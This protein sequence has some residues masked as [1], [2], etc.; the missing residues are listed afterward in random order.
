M[1]FTEGSPLY[2]NTNAISPESLK[3]PG[4][5]NSESGWF[6]S[7][8]L[9]GGRILFENDCCACKGIYFEFINQKNDSQKMNIKHSWIEQ[10]LRSN[11]P[12]I[13]QIPPY[14]MPELED[15]QEETLFSCQIDHK[16]SKTKISN[17]I[18]TNTR[19]LK[20]YDFYKEF[21]VDFEPKVVYVYNT[22]ILQS[23]IGTKTFPLLNES[24]FSSDIDETSKQ[25][26]GFTIKWL[27]DLLSFGLITKM[28]EALKF[29]SFFSPLL[30]NKQ[31]E[32][33]KIIN[34]SI[35]DYFLNV[36]LK[37]PFLFRRLIEQWDEAAFYNFY[38]LRAHVPNIKYFYSQHLTFK[39]V[40]E[41]KN[42][43]ICEKIKQ[44]EDYFDN[45]TLQEAINNFSTLS[46]QV[47]SLYSQNLTKSSFDFI[48][49]D[50]QTFKICISGK[51][52]VGKSTLINRFIR[53]FALT[54]SY[55]FPI[56]FLPWTKKKFMVIVYFISIKEWKEIFKTNKS[57]K[58]QKELIQKGFSINKLT[59]F[60][61]LKDFLDN[62]NKKYKLI[63]RLAVYGKF[64][65][66]LE[67][68]LSVV[69]TPD[70]QNCLFSKKSTF[71][72]STSQIIIYI[73]PNETIFETFDIEMNYMFM[74]EKKCAIVVC[75]REKL[76]FENFPSRL[77]D[78][79]INF[80][81]L[82]HLC[83]NGI[84]FDVQQKV[85]KNLN[86]SY[87]QKFSEMPFFC[88]ENVDS[89]KNDLEYENLTTFIIKFKISNIIDQTNQMI[90]PINFSIET[91]EDKIYEK[92]NQIEI[93]R[94]LVVSEIFNDIRKT[95]PQEK[96]VGNLDIFEDID[97][98]TLKHLMKNS[99][100]IAEKLLPFL[101]HPFNWNKCNEGLYKSF[102]Y[103]KKPIWDQ[104]EAINM[105]ANCRCLITQQ[106]S[107]W[108]SNKVYNSKRTDLAKNIIFKLFEE[109]NFPKYQKDLN[110]EQILK[111]VNDWWKQNK[112]LFLTQFKNL[113][114]EMFKNQA[115]EFYLQLIKSLE[116][117]LNINKLKNTKFLSI[118]SKNNHL[119]FENN[120]NYKNSIFQPLWEK[121]PWI[122]LKNSFISI[123]TKETLS[124][125]LRVHIIE[126]YP[127]SIHFVVGLKEDLIKKP[128]HS[129]HP[130]NILEFLDL[131]RILLS[132]I[133]NG[134]IRT[135]N[136]PFEIAVDI[137]EF[138]ISLI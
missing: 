52:G 128:N 23:K 80:V 28:I 53:P 48:N 73:P 138:L 134:Q 3:A 94:Q 106:L 54:N 110:R 87:K 125:D 36:H 14:L 68:G 132:P 29:A 103:L 20:I 56:E 102:N 78:S 33:N 83:E 61:D 75:K 65:F 17:I 104:I 15:Y 21:V 19:Y 49:V 100:L 27:S 95:M 89:P 108:G 84:I 38:H 5:N 34:Q 88:L 130:P 25:N 71:E 85:L 109:L 67:N 1:R 59:N 81:G 16:I 18:A 118:N 116:N 99:F 107:I 97:F 26:L 120:K 7:H 119:L 124:N 30:N 98:F 50:I 96:F 2:M 63:K 127:G 24:Q 123:I 77:N 115:F 37:R 74:L 70:F 86:T 129:L 51:K 90:I 22:A 66:L 133:Q 42:I 55:I 31:D 41:N 82:E 9:F 45:S 13:P 101:I 40:P 4:S 57:K 113:I 76:A 72:I 105:N 114:I 6:A 117:I 43:I 92:I 69:E 12:E 122:R 135:F 47:E 60:S 136:I 32:E 35:I 112:T 62:S 46:S 64:Q 137:S 10:V 79:K 39:L 8:L 44:E 93:L 121:Y 126:N 131:I 58:K 11:L 91:D 111:S